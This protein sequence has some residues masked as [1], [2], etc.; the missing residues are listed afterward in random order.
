MFG[1]EAAKFNS[2]IFL[3]VDLNDFFL[4]AKNVLPQDAK[5]IDPEG[6]SGSKVIRLPVFF[7][8]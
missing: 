4:A 1:R 7:D 5:G 2:L 6:S 3:K 8:K